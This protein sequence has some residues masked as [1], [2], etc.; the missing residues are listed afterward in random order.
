MVRVKRRSEESNPTATFRYLGG[1]DAVHEADLL[2]SLFAH[3]EANLP[4]LVH[5]FVHHLQRHTRLIQLV[6]H[7]QIHIAAEPV[8]LQWEEER[9]KKEM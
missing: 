9:M 7:I 1:G 3:G 5:S 6:L 8:D 4:P 2:E